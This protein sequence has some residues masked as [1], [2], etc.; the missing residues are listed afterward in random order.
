VVVGTY[1]LTDRVMYLSIRLVRPGDGS[2]LSVY[3]K[4]ICLD[5]RSLQMLGLQLTE[6][7]PFPQPGES[8]LDKL[9]YW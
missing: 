1:T 7:D 9:L 4:R 2:I 3:E 6:E 5:A 8:L